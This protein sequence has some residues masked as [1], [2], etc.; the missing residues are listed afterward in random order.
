M[1][2][3]RRDTRRGGPGE[4]RDAPPRPHES[5]MNG[6]RWNTR[7]GGPGEERAAPPRPD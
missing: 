5:P 1:N 7:R 2:G 4:E 3:W 6:W